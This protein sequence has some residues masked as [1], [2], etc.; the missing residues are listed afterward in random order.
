M[1]ISLSSLLGSHKVKCKDCSCF[2]ECDSVKDNSI[3]HKCMYCKKDYS[4]KLDE[5]LKKIFKN[6]FEF[7]NND[8]SKLI[9]LSLWIYGWMWNV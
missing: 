8:I 5:E 1:S 7:S 6:T 9:L 3:K 2:L 4:N